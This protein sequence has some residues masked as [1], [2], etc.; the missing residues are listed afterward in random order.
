MKYLVLVRHATAEVNPLKSDFE[1]QLTEE[2]RAEAHQT[3]LELAG[4][5]RSNNLKPPLFIS[6]PATRTFQTCVSICKEFQTQKLF[7]GEIEKENQLYRGE[8]PDWL[9]VSLDVEDR[10][11]G[12]IIVGH[13]P[14]L[15][16]FASQLAR[17]ELNFAPGQFVVLSANTTWKDISH[18]KWDLFKSS[19]AHG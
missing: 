8:I 17:V 3:A 1:R 2:G 13:N 12:I 10:Q 9:E 18:T 5:W 14:G 15:S 7:E 11:E 6:S 4:I 16:F 19:L